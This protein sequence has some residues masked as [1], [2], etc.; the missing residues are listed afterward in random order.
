MRG[1]PRIGGQPDGKCVMMDQW[2]DPGQH[3]RKQKHHG[4]EVLCCPALEL[5]YVPGV[6]QGHNH[7]MYMNRQSPRRIP[8][9]AWN[10]IFRQDRV[11]R[12]PLVAC[13]GR[14]TAPS[15]TGRRAPVT[16]GRFAG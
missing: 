7:A 5:Q 1:N 11:W 15:T 13:H 16:R 10:T 8:S 6:R 4:N 14:Q 3:M 2:C 12:R 9:I